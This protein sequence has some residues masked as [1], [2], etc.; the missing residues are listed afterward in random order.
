MTNRSSPRHVQ[1]G[2][3]VWR[4]NG[5]SGS[6][7]SPCHELCGVFGFKDE[8][9]AEEECGGQ[10]YVGNEEAEEG[11]GCKEDEEDKEGKEDSSSCFSFR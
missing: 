7:A 11:N 9:V 10:I 8:E 4:T 2:Q 3:Q 6:Q 5:T 1:S